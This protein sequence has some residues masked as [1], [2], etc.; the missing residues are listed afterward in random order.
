MQATLQRLQLCAPHPSSAS[1]V[2]SGNSTAASISQELTQLRGEVQELIK[3]VALNYL[4]VVKAIKKRNR[5]LK[6]L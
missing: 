2:P 5:H 3:F 4:A 6:V 1:L